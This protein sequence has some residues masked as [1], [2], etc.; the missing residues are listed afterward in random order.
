ME[1]ETSGMFCSVHHVTLS[2]RDSG[3]SAEFY[4]LFGFKAALR[5]M[6][7]DGSLIISHLLREDGFILEL[8]R[9]A[10]NADEPIIEACIG[11]DLER[12]GVKHLAFRVAD[13]RT[14]YS[15]LLTL[16]CGRL[17][18]IQSGR[19]GIDYFFIAD[20]DGNWVEIVEDSRSLSGSSFVQLT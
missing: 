2:V 18:E 5:W 3:K 11:N 9:Y 15:E 19:T 13:L 12:L 16:K 8:F 1:S 14:T 10:E 17:T 7:P 6:A 4:S 20:P